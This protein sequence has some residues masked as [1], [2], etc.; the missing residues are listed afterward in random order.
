MNSRGSAIRVTAHFIKNVLFPAFTLEGF[1]CFANSKFWFPL[2]RMSN[3]LFFFDSPITQHLPFLQG[4]G[5]LWTFTSPCSGSHPWA[6]SGCRPLFG[7]VPPRGMIP[8][9]VRFHGTMKLGWNLLNQHTPGN[10]PLA[11]SQRLPTLW[12]SGEGRST[13]PASQPCP[14]NPGPFA[15]A[16][17][18]QAMKWSHEFPAAVQQQPAVRGQGSV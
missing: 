5:Q 6:L 10:H 18:A 13:L 14:C 15:E 8:Y 17:K 7:I 16:G 11:L 3:S 4:S 1:Y 2:K 12:Q 9:Q